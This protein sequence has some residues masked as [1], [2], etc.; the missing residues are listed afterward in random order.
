MKAINVYS[1]NTV[2]VIL[3]DEMGEVFNLIPI[4]VFLGQLFMW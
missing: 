2:V 4:P 1:Y 3:S